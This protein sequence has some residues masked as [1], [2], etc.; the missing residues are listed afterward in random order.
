MT[1]EKCKMSF[2]NLDKKIC[3]NC[4]NGLELINH[5]KVIGIRDKFSKEGLLYGIYHGQKSSAQRR[6][7][8]LPTY[9]LFALIEWCMNQK[10]YHKLFEAWEKS[11][12]KHELVPSIN[13]L[14]ES[15]SYSFDNI[16]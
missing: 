12:Y 8:P 5:R 15:K 10:T 6:R 14:D 13:R 11:G 4:K 1:C 3:F 2:K 16:E 9:S 7:H